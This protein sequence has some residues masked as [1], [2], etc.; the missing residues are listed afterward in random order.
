MLEAGPAGVGVGDESDP[1]VIG[2]ILAGDWGGGGGS[3]NE[4]AAEGVDGVDVCMG[5]CWPVMACTMVLCKAA[6]CAV[7]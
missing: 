5:W 3:V 6:S 7:R 2:G 4:R 1:K